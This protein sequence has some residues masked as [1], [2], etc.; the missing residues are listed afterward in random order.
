MEKPT[1]YVICGPTATGKTDHAIQLAKEIDGEVISA[2]SRQVY[3]GLDIGTAKVT[4]EEMDGIPH[5]LIDV[6]DATKT[7]TVADFKKLGQEAIHDILKRGKTP[8]ICGG[9]GYYIDALLYDRTIPEV[10]ANLELRKELEKLS[11]E[12][13]QEKLKKADLERYETIDKQNPVRLVRALE[14]VEALGKVPSNKELLNQV[15][16]DI[17][18]TT[19]PLLSKEGLGVVWIYLDHLDEVLEKRIHDRNVHRIENGLIEEIEN[20]HKEGLSWERMHDL[21][22]EYRY[23]SEFLQGKIESTE[24]LIKILDVKTRQFVKRQRTWFKKHIPAS[25][26]Q[27]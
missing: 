5:H 16:D 19:S 17:S 23:V 21:G 12:E 4:P 20:L 26:F 6:T 3:R 14:I 18:N 24:E 1:L 27:K 15:Q 25:V 10:P 22:L 8:I 7:F 13:L 9:T 11:L 2:D